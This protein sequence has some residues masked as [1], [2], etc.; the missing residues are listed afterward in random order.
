MTRIF[1]LLKPAFFLILFLLDT[2]AAAMDEADTEE[3]DGFRFHSSSYP[4]S[5]ADASPSS[6]SSPRLVPLVPIH[7]KSS[8][9]AKRKSSSLLTDS[10]GSAPTEEPAPKQAT[11]A[12]PSSFLLTDLRLDEIRKHLLHALNITTTDTNPPKF[13]LD[14][15]LEYIIPEGFMDTDQAKDPAIIKQIKSLTT[16]M[17]ILEKM[18]I[19]TQPA[20]AAHSSMQP[21]EQFQSPSSDEEDEEQPPLTTSPQTPSAHGAS[22]TTA[23]PPAHHQTMTQ[24]EG[25]GAVVS[26]QSTK[27]YRHIEKGEFRKTV[28]E[29]IKDYASKNHHG[30]QTF[31]PRQAADILRDH[32]NIDPRLPGMNT[33]HN[34][35]ILKTLTE[36]AR[37]QP[38]HNIEKSTSVSSSAAVPYS[39][40]QALSDTEDEAETQAISASTIS[41]QQNT[42]SL[43]QPGSSSSSVPFSATAL[44]SAN[45]QAMSKNED[46]RLWSEL[47][48]KALKEDAKK[49]GKPNKKWEIGEAIGFLEKIHEFNKFFQIKN[50]GHK[51][52][53][54]LQ[55]KNMWKNTRKLNVPTY[56]IEEGDTPL[57]YT[58]KDILGY[59]KKHEEKNANDPEIHKIYTSA[60]A[61]EV[62]EKSRRFDKLFNH[63]NPGQ[64]ISNALRRHQLLLSLAMPDP[65]SSS[66]SINSE[67]PDIH[68]PQ[69]PGSSSSSSSATALPTAHPQAMHESEDE[70]D[71]E[72]V[73]VQPAQSYHPP[74]GAHPSF[75][76]AT[77]PLE[78]FQPPN[79]PSS[80]YFPY[81]PPYDYGPHRPYFPAP[82]GAHPYHYHYGPHRP[83]FPA[84]MGAHP[85]FAPIMPQS[86]QTTHPLETPQPYNSRSSSSSP[87][88]TRAPAERPSSP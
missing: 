79:G 59:L 58:I 83:Y 80:Y 55:N 50:A 22:P 57:G 70:G 6:S 71:I 81:T 2:M 56:E 68:L 41:W 23:L 20:P 78:T 87:L 12:A 40:P 26:V 54:I 45:H 82:M 27:A 53:L 19:S 44:P 32:Y 8:A 88:R 13:T 43:Q 72:A 49:K 51:V 25:E 15:L 66:A 33:R 77:H 64:F 11:L 3:I 84:P 10:P 31:T 30:P 60:G 35:S 86:H 73:P 38:S 34:T 46:E 61:K 67:K 28:G 17:G 75:A 24:N 1:K 52:L 9:S 62:L 47:I 42:H 48:I 4:V 65:A 14:Q 74:M 21:L 69:Q 18:V 29:L 36:I 76:P 16:Q 63:Q 5:P 7:P 39:H 85:S 37:Y